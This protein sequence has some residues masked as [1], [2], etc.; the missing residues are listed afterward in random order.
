MLVIPEG[1]WRLDVD[2]LA[3]STDPGWS[4]RRV[5][6]SCLHVLKFPDD[7]KKKKIYKKRWT[8]NLQLYRRSR[9]EVL[10]EDPRGPPGQ[11]ES[12][13][14]EETGYREGG[15]ISS[16][17][18]RMVKWNWCHFL[19]SV[20]LF[21]SCPQLISKA[22]K[23]IMARAKEAHKHIRFLDDWVPMVGWA[24]TLSPPFFTFALKLMMT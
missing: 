16:T 22:E 12:S 8:F 20:Y 18:R 3:F 24:Q 17:G 4:I 6:M 13:Q 5:S 1:C 9:A 2:T 21:L 19:P 14:R 23:I 7:L 10:A 11:V 15:M